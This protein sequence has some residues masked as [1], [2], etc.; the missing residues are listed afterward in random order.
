MVCLPLLPLLLLLRFLCRYVEQ[1]VNQLEVGMYEVGSSQ[2][3]MQF[4]LRTGLVPPPP[5]PSGAEPSAAAAA[6]QP[7]AVPSSNGGVPSPVSS[8]PEQVGV[9]LQLRSVCQ[10]RLCYC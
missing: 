8:P 9:H 7:A 1:S 5:P 2:K 4:K 6:P 10:L 3:Y